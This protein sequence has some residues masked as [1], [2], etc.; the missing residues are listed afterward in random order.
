MSMEQGR[1]TRQVIM[2]FLCFYTD[3][4]GWAPTMREIGGAVGL[5]S[6]STV[7][8]HLRTL[9]REGRIVLGGGPRMIRVLRRPV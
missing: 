9:E 1:R 2:D 3:E 4:H 8:S 5:A 6:P 7:L